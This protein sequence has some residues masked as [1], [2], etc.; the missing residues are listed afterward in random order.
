[1]TKLIFSITKFRHIPCIK[2]IKNVSSSITSHGLDK[3]V[4]HNI[5][6]IDKYFFHECSMS[7]GIFLKFR[8]FSRKIK[9]QFS[10]F[11]MT[12]TFTIYH[13]NISSHFHPPWRIINFYFIIIVYNTST[14]ISGRCCFR[15][16]KHINLNK[17]SSEYTHLPSQ[18]PLLPTSQTASATSGV[19][20][21]VKEDEYTVRRFDLTGWGRTK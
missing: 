11:S 13:P 20:G 8:E 15:G 1:M 6:F 16:L 2:L 7:L 19:A 4:H 9:L 3:N 17:C 14:S 21:L 18:G 12:R 10:R 5:C